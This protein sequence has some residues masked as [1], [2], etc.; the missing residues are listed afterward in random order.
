LQEDRSPP[1]VE[2]QEHH[3]MVRE[4]YRQVLAAM[5]KLNDDERDILSLAVSSELSYREI[6]SITGISEGNVKVKVHR[7][8]QKLRKLIQAGE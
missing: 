3:L 2:D 5:S 1:V 6:A 4:Q 7:S 8:R